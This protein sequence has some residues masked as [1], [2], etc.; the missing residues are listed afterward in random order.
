AASKKLD[1]AVLPKAAQNSV[2]DP[3]HLADRP[4]F[5]LAVV[6]AWAFLPSKPKVP[7]SN[8]QELRAT[9]QSVERRSASPVSL[10]RWASTTFLVLSGSFVIGVFQCWSPAL[11]TQ[12]QGV[13]PEA[14]LKWLVI[15]SASA[16]VFGNFAAPPLIEAWGLQWRLKMALA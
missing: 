3:P 7:P 5:A 14:L 8:S 15:I 16:S 10:Q 13:L 11:P 6:V 4:G 2:A 1:F 12:L 9:A